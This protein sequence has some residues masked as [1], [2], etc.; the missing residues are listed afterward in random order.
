MI[1]LAAVGLLRPE[2]GSWYFLFCNVYS[3]PC[4]CS[5]RTCEW[6]VIPFLFYAEEE[7]GKN[8]LGMSSM[9]GKSLMTENE[10]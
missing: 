7:G 2:Q 5:K 3:K 1:K 6:A 9:Q 8:T 4:V 10:S